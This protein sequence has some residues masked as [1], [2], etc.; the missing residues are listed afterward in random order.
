MPLQRVSPLKQCLRSTVALP[1][2]IGLLLYFFQ[3][4]RGDDDSECARPSPI[5]AGYFG[6]QLAA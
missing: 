6:S 4:P 2:M 5:G 3:A 1:G